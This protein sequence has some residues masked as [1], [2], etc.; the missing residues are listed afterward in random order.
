MEEA[1]SIYKTELGIFEQ[2]TAVSLREIDFR[3]WGFAWG[4]FLLRTRSAYKSLK[5]MEFQRRKP[6]EI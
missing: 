6:A 3:P 5:D 4:T 1:A 2:K